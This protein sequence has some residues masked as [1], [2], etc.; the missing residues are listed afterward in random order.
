V[1]DEI[2][3][4]VFPAIAFDRPD[5]TV[6]DDDYLLTLEAPM[7]I[8]RE[9]AN[10]GADIFGDLLADERDVALDDPFYEDGPTGETLLE[11][12]IVITASFYRRD[13]PHP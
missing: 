11:A 13:D 1:L 5:D 12:L 9:A 6:Y 7:A 3:N 8:K 2:E 4:V 10:N